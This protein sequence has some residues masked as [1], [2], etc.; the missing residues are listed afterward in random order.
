MGL[1]VGSSEYLGS[2]PHAAAVFVVGAVVVEIGIVHVVVA[3]AA[4]SDVIPFLYKIHSV[5]NTWTTII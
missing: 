5:K 3:A 1:V 4:V 2:F